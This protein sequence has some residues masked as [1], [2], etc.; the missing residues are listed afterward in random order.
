MGGITLEFDA[1]TDGGLGTDGN[2]MAGV[3]VTVEFRNGSV[4]SGE[5]IADVNNPSRGL[6]QL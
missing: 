5:I 2:A 4:S 3:V 1:D 6:V